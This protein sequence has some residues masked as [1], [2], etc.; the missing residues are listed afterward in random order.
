MQELQMC[1]AILQE[2]NRERTEM[3]RIVSL[4]EQVQ[5]ETQAVEDKQTRRSRALFKICSYSTLFPES[6]HP[7]IQPQHM[8][9]VLM[10]QV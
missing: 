10:F 2:T 9:Q 8:F 6:D 5:G 4:F 7:L 1:E 3:E